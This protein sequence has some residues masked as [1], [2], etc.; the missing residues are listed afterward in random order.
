MWGLEPLLTRWSHPILRGHTTAANHIIIISYHHTP[1]S[2]QVHLVKGGDALWPHVQVMVVV[3]R[4]GGVDGD[5]GCGGY[6]SGDGSA[7]HS[8]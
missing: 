5:G 4:S 3:S 2:S 1:I 7:D 8:L 6:D